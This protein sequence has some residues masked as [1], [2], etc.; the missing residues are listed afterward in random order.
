MA[1]R[2]LHENRKGRAAGSRLKGGRTLQDEKSKKDKS[3]I[4]YCPPTTPLL[5]VNKT[6]DL[7]KNLSCSGNLTKA[8]V[9]VAWVRKKPEKIKT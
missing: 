1:S 3:I 6:E 2:P 9:S 8:S 5:K 7:R 4:R